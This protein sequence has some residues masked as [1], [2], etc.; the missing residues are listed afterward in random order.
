LPGPRAFAFPRECAFCVESYKGDC[1]PPT[2]RGRLV[3][4][5]P[6][7]KGNVFVAKIWVFFPPFLSPPIQ[8]NGPPP[9]PPPFFFQPTPEKPAPTV[10][11]IPPLGSVVPPGKMPRKRPVGSPTPSRSPLVVSRGNSPH[12]PVVPLTGNGQR[13]PKS[14]PKSFR[15]PG[16]GPSPGLLAGAA[17]WPP[18]PPTPPHGFFPQAPKN[19]F[20]GPS[21]RLDERRLGRRVCEIFSATLASIPRHKFSSPRPLALPPLIP[22]R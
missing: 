13:T 9:A 8:T 3:G 12:A 4:V 10:C 6:T 14:G 20:P 2:K 18:P 22:H 16:P 17:R 1:D 21:P 15:A 7:R 11:Q 19:P 5:V